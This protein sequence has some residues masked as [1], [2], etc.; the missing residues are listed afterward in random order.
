ML[1]PRFETERLMLRP[2]TI[3]DF[4][5]CLAM[6]RDRQVTRFVPGPWNDPVQHERFLRDRLEEHFGEGLGYWSIMPKEHPDTFL[7][8]VLLIPRDGEGPEIEIGWR[9]IRRAW[10]KGYA[11][12]AARPVIAHAFGTLRLPCIVADIHPRNTASM[13]VAEKIGLTYRGNGEYDGI[14]CKHY[15]MSAEDHA[16][17]A[18]R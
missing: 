9:L 6:D 16:R 5:D 2:R 1:L 8:W 11:T 17:A 3:D 15:V 12:E 7:G 4:A 18:G 14:P 13:R 10:G